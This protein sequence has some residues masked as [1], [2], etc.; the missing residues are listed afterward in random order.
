MADTCNIPKQLR[1][2]LAI[3]VCTA[4]RVHRTRWQA[5]AQG[6][7]RDEAANKPNAKLAARMT[8]RTRI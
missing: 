4:A 8:K 1:A 5:I 6:V 3:F 7:F 2:L